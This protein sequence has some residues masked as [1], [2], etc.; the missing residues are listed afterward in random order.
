MGTVTEAGWWWCFP[1]TKRE[2]VSL[3]VRNFQSEQIKVND[4]SG[5]P[6]ELGAVIVWLTRSRASLASSQA[7]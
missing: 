6:I 3:R 1:F 5:N 4:A 7:P 2:Q